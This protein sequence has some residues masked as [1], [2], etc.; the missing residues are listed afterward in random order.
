MGNEGEPI[1]EE[2]VIGG[3]YIHMQNPEHRYTMSAVLLDATGWEESGKV[4]SRRVVYM[5]DYDGSFPAGTNWTRDEG[6]FLGTTDV[7]GQEVRKFTL[8]ENPT[9][10]PLT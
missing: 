7:N 9:E 6:D 5:Q 8:V 10:E 3:T 2:V 4:S 1:P